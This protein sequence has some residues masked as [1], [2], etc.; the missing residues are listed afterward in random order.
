[1]ENHLKLAIEKF[2]NKSIP[3]KATIVHQESTSGIPTNVFFDFLNV[4]LFSV[5]STLCEKV[6]NFKPATECLPWTVFCGPHKCTSI[7]QFGLLPY[8][9]PKAV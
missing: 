1:L 9:L 3:H 6:T 4:L 7:Q 2:F 5:R 8:R